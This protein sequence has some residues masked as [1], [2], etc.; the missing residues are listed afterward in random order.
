MEHTVSVQGADFSLDEVLTGIR[1][2][3]RD[4]GAVVAFVGLVR[5]RAG[6]AI[7]GDVAA[8]ALYL[9]H[10]PG[11]TERSI[12][13][14]V[15]TAAQRWPLLEVVVI[16][17]VGWLQPTEQ[18]VLVVCASRHRQAAF[19]AASFLMDYLKTDAVLWKKERTGDGAETWIEAT[20]ADHAASD[21]W[22]LGAREEG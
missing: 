11:V 8:S 1:G 7:T 6:Q 20:A 12:E 19:A 10:Y 13:A 5:E 22:R 9:E 2:R 21:Q 17:R 15:A 3:H 18:I 14:I 16:H 4:V